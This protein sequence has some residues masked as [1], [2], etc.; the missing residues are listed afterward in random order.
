V[1][2]VYR[3]TLPVMLIA[4][5]GCAAMNGYPPQVGDREKELQQLVKDY[6]ADEVIKTY[7]GK[8]GADAKRLYR[9]EVVNGRIRVIDI[10]FISYEKSLAGER[11]KL[12]V[13]TDMTILALT[14][15]SAVMPGF[16]VARTVL[17][18][19]AAFITGTKASIDK[20]VYFE[21]TI[22][23]LFAK[24]ESL[25]KQVLVRIRGQLILGDDK[26]TL[27]VALADVDD[28]YKAGTMPAAL[29][30]IMEESG[31]SANK[32]D[33]ELKEIA[34]YN[35][36]PDENSIKIRSYWRHGGKADPE[37][38][39]IINYL[40]NKYVEDDEKPVI[41]DFINNIEFKA[42]RQKVVEELEKNYNVVE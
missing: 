3:L 21:K 28:Y 5:A 9:D 10:Q 17:S 4:I 29:M 19:V 35:Y 34:T 26:Y 8:S 20:K 22:P 14:G 32:A 38:A 12:D 6:Y 36:G 7:I 27:Y 30:G 23:V 41:G 31:A 37:R 2:T 42:A 24:M 39:K 13:G 33:K 16:E 40:I 18:A 15:T 11:V 25:R 1:R